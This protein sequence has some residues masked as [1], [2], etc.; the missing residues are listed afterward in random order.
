MKINNFLLSPCET[1]TDLSIATKLRYK[2]YRHVN[3]IEEN[4][5]KEFSDKYDLQNNTKTCLI[6]EG[7]EAVA[8]VRACIY[9]KE[10]DYLPI[11][12]FEVYKEE[13]AKEIGLDKTIIESNR[14][15]VIPEKKDSK[16]LFKHPY[17]FIILNSLK[18]DSDFVIAAVREK[19]I[20]LYRRFLDMEPISGLKKYPGINVEMILMAVDCRKFRQG[21][22]EKEEAYAISKEEIEYYSL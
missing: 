12:A 6:Y 18:F 22:M 20:P 3:A 21:I 13:I 2:A 17:K 1:T 11:P 15:V 4:E 16:S 19:H 14:Y 7:N 10:Y 5:L 9:S 8:A